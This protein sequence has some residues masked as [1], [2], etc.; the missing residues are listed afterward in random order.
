MLSKLYP[1]YTH[2]SPFSTTAACEALGETEKS[3][4]SYV[5]VIKRETCDGGL[6]CFINVLCFVGMLQ[7]SQGNTE[8]GSI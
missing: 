2:I 7:Q 8:N 6:I 5:Y 4:K 1:P 3:K